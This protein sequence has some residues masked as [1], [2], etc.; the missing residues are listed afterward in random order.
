MVSQNWDRHYLLRQRSV[1]DRVARSGSHGTAAACIDG[2]AANWHWQNGY[3]YLIS[4]RYFTPGS[5]RLSELRWDGPGSTV[6]G[7]LEYGCKR[8]RRPCLIKD[9]CLTACSMEL[10]WIHHGSRQNAS[11]ARSEGQ[12]KHHRCC[13]PAEQ[14]P[15]HP[16][17][18]RIRFGVQR[19]FVELFPWTSIHP[20][21]SAW[22][23][24][25]YGG[26]EACAPADKSFQR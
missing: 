13:R 11:R 17:T 24:K 16:T 20:S 7:G 22:C 23:R 25:F 15:L 8:S 10:R 21:I 4:A 9:I 12:G 26:S 18:S 6:T 19:G 2:L 5:S 3:S 1:R 14:M